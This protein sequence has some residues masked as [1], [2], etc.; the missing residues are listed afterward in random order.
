MA[1]NYYMGAEI[2]TTTS[3]FLFNWCIVVY[4][5]AKLRTDISEEIAE[6]NQPLLIS[7]QGSHYNVY[8]LY[9]K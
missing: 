2:G 5:K 8:D 7:D 1:T 4:L 6:N 9:L 3:L